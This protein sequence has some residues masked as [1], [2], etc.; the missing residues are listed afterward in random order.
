MTVTK[1]IKYTYIESTVVV[2]AEWW[3]NFIVSLL[4]STTDMRQRVCATNTSLKVKVF[5]FWVPHKKVRLSVENPRVSSERIDKKYHLI[6]VKHRITK[7]WPILGAHS[8]QLQSYNFPQVQIACV[9]FSWLLLKRREKRG[10]VSA[11]G[12]L[13]S[14]Q[15]YR[16]S[17][18]S[19]R[20]PTS[21]SESL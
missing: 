3:Q 4:P 19:G 9:E 11:A 16:Q 10:K 8:G 12:I 6:R 14:V 18:P 1:S 2:I 21:C 17:R 5:K 15:F 20:L 13:H 7:E